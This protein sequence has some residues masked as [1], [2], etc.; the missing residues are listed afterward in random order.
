MTSRPLFISVAES[1][2]FFTP[3]CQVGWASA[4]ATVAAAICSAVRS[5]TARRRGEHDRR[6]ALARLALQALEDRGVL[7]VDGQQRRAAARRVATSSSPAATMSSLFATAT[8]MPR[9]TA[10]NTASNATAPSVAASTICASL[11]QATACSPRAPS[12]ASA[13]TR[14]PK[15]SAC[16]ASRSTL[17]PA[18]SPTTSNR[19]GWRA[20]TS[21]AWR[22]MLP[23]L[24]RIATLCGHLSLSKGHELTSRY[25]EITPMAY[26]AK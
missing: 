7:A 25:C 15:R 20:I 19:S 26:S 10:A 18:A 16:C 22:P 2:V 13:T 9:S 8:S 14:G 4:S 23:V 3:I 24:P 6:D 21:S 12:R 17:R 5:R 1:M 11:S